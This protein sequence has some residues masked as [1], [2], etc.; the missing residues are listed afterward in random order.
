[1]YAVNSQ[2][3]RVAKGGK[4]QGLTA[5]MVALASSGAT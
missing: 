4:T 3:F 1:M 5:R 2:G